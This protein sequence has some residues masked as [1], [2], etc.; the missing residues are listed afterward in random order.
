MSDLR[1]HILRVLFRAGTPVPTSGKAADALMDEIED[2]IISA[3]KDYADSERA[4]MIPADSYLLR[5]GATAYEQMKHLH[6]DA[7][8]IA[9]YAFGERRTVQISERLHDESR[10]LKGETDAD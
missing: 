6:D 7:R 9:K 5:F 2:R 8:N 3:I 1:T 10:W 4:A